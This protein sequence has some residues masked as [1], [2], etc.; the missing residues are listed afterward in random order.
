MAHL[1]SVL[2]EPT[3]DDDAHQVS[4]GRRT[5]RSCDSIP[6]VAFAPIRSYS[7]RAEPSQVGGASGHFFISLSLHH[8]LP[9]AG[10]PDAVERRHSDLPIDLIAFSAALSWLP[11]LLSARRYHLLARASSSPLLQPAAPF[12]CS[13]ATLCAAPREHR[14]AEE[15]RRR[16]MH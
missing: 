14:R 4:I 7:N 10:R 12:T 3:G 5:L 13:P 9:R 6:S 1:N 15:R 11:L 2:A 16:L 8:L